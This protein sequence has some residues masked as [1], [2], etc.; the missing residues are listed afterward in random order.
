MRI[1][2]VKLKTDH[3]ITEILHD[4]GPFNKAQVYGYRTRH[5][6]N[7]PQ[8]TG[9]RQMMNDHAR[10]LWIVLTL[11]LHKFIEKVSHFKLFPKKV[12]HMSTLPV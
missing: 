2:Y 3:E 1:R 9:P 5:L 4:C 11:I 8:Q 6:V 7:A 10:H 12:V